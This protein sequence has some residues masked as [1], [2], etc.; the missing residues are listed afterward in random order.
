[1]S[2]PVLGATRVG[3]AA[4]TVHAGRASVLLRPRAVVV[5]VAAVAVAACLFVA[6]LAIGRTDLPLTAVLG[7]LFGYGEPSAILTVQQFR[8]P[9]ALVGLL[10]GLAL[11]SAGAL[12]QGLARNPLASPDVLGVT[13]GA[14]A[15]AVVVLLSQGSTASRAG[16]A[17][18]SLSQVGL[19]LGAV[20]GAALAAV[21][22][23]VLTGRR[24]ME[25]AGLDPHRLILVGVVLAAA[26][27]GVVEYALVS[28][29]VDQATRATVWLTGSLHARGWEHVWGVAA[30]LLLLLPVSGVLVRRLDVLLLGDST[31]TALGVRVAAIRLG[32]VAA[33]VA[34]AGTATAAAGPVAFVALVAPNLAR[35][36]VQGPGV[37]L[38][39]SAALGAVVLLGADLLARRVIPGT[40]LPAGAVCAL[41]GAPYL[42]YLILHT[43]KER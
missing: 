19:P 27:T 16:G 18:A 13:A 26:F 10:V 31:A 8:L 12:T 30:A 1:M 15:G 2:A 35:R 39:S 42:L 9:R 21:L 3:G 17:A 4:V 38:V 22:V 7:G 25:G 6:G 14:S 11:G 28:G 32:V 20:A 34:L 33:A 41:V 5:G 23:L 36:L 29:D 37:P 40:E 43:S 24:R